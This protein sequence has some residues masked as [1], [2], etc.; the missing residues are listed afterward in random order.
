MKGKYFNLLFVIFFIIA[1]GSFVRLYATHIRAGEITAERLN[2]NSREYKFTF[3]GYRDTSSNIQFGQGRITFGDGSGS[4]ILDEIKE[5]HVRTRLG[6]A[7]EVNIITFTHTFSSTGEFLITYKE[8]NRNPGIRNIPNSV[9]VPFYIETKIIIDPFIGCNNTPVLL[10][11]PV[12]TAAVGAKYLHN[13]GAYDKDG[14]S[15]SFYL[16]LCKFDKDEPIRGYKYPNDAEFGGRKED[17]SPN[18][19]FTIDA[20]S[21]DL[22]W[23]S[24][25]MI[26]EYNVAFV[27]EEWRKK[28][29]EWHFLG[30]VT[31][32]MQIIVMDTENKRPELEV[33][34]DTCI[35]AGTI[36][37]GVI[38]GKD[39]EGHP[40]KIETFSGVYELP[41]FPATYSPRP[42]RYLPSPASMEVRWQ[43][44][45]I[46]VRERPYTF[47]FKV[48]DNPPLG[49]GLVDFKSWNVRVIAPAPEG[50]LA[51]VQTNG[52]INLQWDK[53][54]CGNAETI[55]IWRRI[56]SFDFLPEG[57]VTGMPQYAGYELIAEVPVSFVGYVDTNNGKG[58]SPGT[59]Y[60][61]RLVAQF[62]QPAGG[63]SYASDEVCEE[64][65]LDAPV[66]THVSVEKTDI[67]KGEIFVQWEE[68]LDADPLFF[69]PPYTY[70]IIR[71]RGLS[72][73][74]EEAVLGLTQN[75]SFLDNGL[76]TLNN[77]YNY[78]IRLI[79][80]SGFN[81]AI[82]ESSKASSVRLDAVP[83]VGKIKLT[84]QAVVP[85]N[86]RVQKYPW[87]YIYR[88]KVDDS[89]PDKMVL[90]DSILVI[91]ANFQ[92][93]DDGRFNGEPLVD[94]NLYAYFIITQGA[95][96][97][98]SFMEPF[99]N[100]SQIITAQPNDTIP[101]CS[102]IS[103]KIQPIE[104]CE[105]YVKQ[106]DCDYNRFENILTWEAAVD[107]ACDLE[108]QEYKVYFS[109]TGEEG[110]FTFIGTTFENRYVHGDL[111]SKAGCYMIRAVDRSG[112]ESEFTEKVCIDNCPFFL[113]PNIFTPNGDGYNEVFAAYPGVRELCPRFVESVNMKIYNRWGAEVYNFRS[114]GENTIYINW[115][116]NDLKG[117]PL[118]DGVYYYVVEVD[119]I[120][121]DP[122]NKRKKYNGWVR[123][124][125]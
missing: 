37:E 33:P 39:P 35:L 75:T 104:D 83:N 29:G 113:L 94:N 52:N 9:G 43:T 38:I 20:F 79:G 42:P 106:L 71:F 2:C 48:V 63:E 56:N 93:I 53:Y 5:T 25:G 41:N 58:F 90:I 22:V 100:K 119:F 59:K 120:T 101:P 98:S 78:K 46:H 85:W 30:Y 114:F 81:Q 4:F 15:L 103:L 57:C 40:V 115:E 55:Q 21:G 117:K 60:C 107:P 27:V 28:E 23:D 67:E 88:N 26:G 65:R 61:Y 118:P 80:T 14:D 44:D 99:L 123:L 124:M 96:G 97:S 68:P 89:D 122:E 6:T 125:K 19:T 3:K 111:S 47:H 13:P 66:I 69:T 72:G 11:P 102:P 73:N 64:T 24:P 51:K 116:G 62:G 86:N 84:W 74:T 109:T 82:S 31:R 112:N 36:L 91:G 50:L 95:Y 12:D 16:E 121:I 76:N 49:P 70:E 7:V 77:S 17:G 18:P 108:V 34:K 8:P 32:D 87:H 10:I 105:S 45:C 54:N 110:S 1:P 92:Y